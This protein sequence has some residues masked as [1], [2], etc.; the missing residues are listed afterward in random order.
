MIE[1]LIDALVNRFFSLFS[2]KSKD[3]FKPKITELMVLENYNQNL[4]YDK[5]FGFSET[6]KKEINGKSLEKGLHSLVVGST[7]YGKSTLQSLCL[8]DDASL[9]KS[10]ISIDPK[11]DSKGWNL[12]EKICVDENRVPIRIGEL[13]SIDI[14]NEGSTNQIADKVHSSF[15]WSEQYYSTVALRALRMAISR[16][17]LRK[18]KIDFKIL[19]EEVR[20]L[21][22]TDE[23]NKRDLEGLLN[24]LENIVFSDLNKYFSPYGKSIREYWKDGS[25]IYISLSKLG[26]P[27]TS[28][29]IGKLILNEINQTVFK[30]YNEVIDP[31]EPA[32]AVFID[33][34]YSFITDEF[35]EL[36]N[37]CRGAKVELNMAFQTPSDIKR[38]NTD[39][40]DQLFENTNNWFIMNQ[41]VDNYVNYL[42]K[43]I[44]TRTSVKKT[45]RVDQGERTGSF[46]EREVEELIVHPN[47]IKR[48][49]IGQCIHL[50]QR[51]FS[52][53][54]IKLNHIEA[55]ENPM[56]L[57]EIVLKDSDPEIFV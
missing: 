34:L 13:N 29:V 37:K 20:E 18:E 2:L 17:R 35:I 55:P 33:E 57:A 21:C 49:D 4:V 10:I 39:L 30:K 3:N 51:P 12:F 52:V 42:S 25:C 40:M 9:G 11:G 38:V 1:S 32:L 16:L 46:S 8:R 27:S 50:Q 26:Y 28:K 19:M 15:E 31:S 56:T 54:L 45:E 23:F 41:R 14:L 36:L 6:Y 22:N 53:D 24:N 7:G 5:S 44:G 47:V 43:A 48:L